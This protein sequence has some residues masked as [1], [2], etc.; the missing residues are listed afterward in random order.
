VL[1]SALVTHAPTWRW[2]AVACL[3]WAIA[4]FAVAGALLPRTAQL[5][6]LLV[7]IGLFA[8]G[9]LAVAAAAHHRRAA[10]RTAGLL[11]ETSR[12]AE[13]RSLL[14]RVSRAATSSLNLH[15]VLGEIA[16]STLGIAGIESAL[17]ELWHP[18]TD[19]LEVGAHRT[20]P[21][22]PGVDEPG[23]RYPLSRYEIDRPILSGRAPAVFCIDD[24]SLDPARRVEMTEEGTGSML[25]FPLWA[26]DR[27]LGLLNL[28]S[29]TVRAFGDDATRLGG[30]IA[31]QTALAIENARLLETERAR[32]LEWAVLNRVSRAA[33]AG[34]GR[35]T[36]L[37]HIA[38][39]CLGIAG[40]ECC[41]IHSY[42]S[43]ADLLILEADVTIPEWPGVEEPGKEYKLQP[44]AV[45]HRAQA[46]GRPIIVR[47]LDD[48]LNDDDREVMELH[49]IESLLVIPVWLSGEMTGVI[50]LCSRDPLAFSGNAVRLGEE[51][52]A[53]AALALSNA[54][55][56]EETRRF[57]EEQATLLEVSRAVSSGRDVHDVLNDIARASLVIAD[58]ELCEIEVL[59]E[60][61]E[62]TEIAAI[63]ALPSWPVPPTLLGK[64]LPLSD[65]PMTERVLASKQPAVF[66]PDSTEL[67][68]LERESLF[69]D[70]HNSLLVVPMVVDDRAVGV[71]CYYATSRR[72]FSDASVRLGS[73]L[74]SHAAIAIERAR[75]HA[76]LREQ[77]NTDGLTGVLNHRAIQERLDAELARAHRDEGTVA[78]LMI[79]LNRFKYVNDTFGHQAGDIVLQRAAA[80]LRGAVR[81]Y[82]VVGRYGGDEFMVILPGADM[83]EGMS[84]AER[85]IRDTAAVRL[86]SPLTGMSISISVGLAVFPSQASTR[87]ELIDLADQEMYRVKQHR[88]RDPLPAARLVPAVAD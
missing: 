83:V 62:A 21:A 57:A 84:V 27:C 33:I 13:E 9:G 73:E 36:V 82:D 29:R 61:G 5:A 46:L 17:I 45:E 60:D 32:A 49:G 26:G 24:P 35:R 86:A 64:R 19:E 7:G 28:F 18:E 58:A 15:E 80:V 87:Q 1:R 44:G 56:V 22:W 78:V 41:T 10:H 16:E 3:S 67:I 63:Q 74:A 6:H 31:A 76:A 23:L 59:S 53:Q 4:G 55:L 85:I 14:L 66:G 2:I 50:N 48:D 75:L 12:L 69:D 47:K 52:A 42:V 8:C 38:N 40:T 65:W 37:T 43:D 68:S 20:V 30:E 72:G 88:S 54:A 77:A 70:R 81:A 11:A 51:I 39:A 79:D 34:L 25:L 71:V